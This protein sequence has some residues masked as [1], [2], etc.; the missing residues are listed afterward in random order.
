MEKLAALAFLVALYVVFTAITV[1]NYGWVTTGVIMAVALGLVIF[2]RTATMV[3]RE[4]MAG[5]A[6]DRFWLGLL[7]FAQNNPLGQFI[8]SWEGLQWVRRH[9]G[10]RLAKLG[11][12]FYPNKIY[13][14]G[15][16]FTAAI[17]AGAR[18]VQE[19]V[20]QA[21]EWPFCQEVLPEEGR[22]IRLLLAAQRSLERG[23]LAT[24]FFVAT[25]ITQGRYDDG[26]LGYAEGLNWRRLPRSLRLMAAAT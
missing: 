12:K 25:Y 13:M 10:E 23:D 14:V 20:E 1:A 2:R 3:I 18:T 15:W 16:G 4:I 22:A 17:E 8:F 9:L 5:P 11:R 19:V 21:K 6:G 24:A 26:C 7:R